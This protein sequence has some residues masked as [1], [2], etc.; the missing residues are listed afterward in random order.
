MTCGTQ[1]PRRRVRTLE[2]V[3]GDFARDPWGA[4]EEVCLLKGV[5]PPGSSHAFTLLA[6]I[7]PFHLSSPKWGAPALPSFCCCLRSAT[8][9]GLALFSHRS[10]SRIFIMQPD[11]SPPS[12][13]TQDDDRRPRGGEERVGPWPPSALSFKDVH[14][15]CWGGGCAESGPASAWAAVRSF[16]Q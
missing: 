9:W 10:A 11:C 5:D 2:R 15:P 8:P 16:P 4:S 3:S 6:F 12:A 13:V 14:H 1:P 7:A